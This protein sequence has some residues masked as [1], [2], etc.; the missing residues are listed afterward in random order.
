[1]LNLFFFSLLVAFILNLCFFRYSSAITTISVIK[2]LV[3]GAGTTIF[4]SRSFK[5]TL[6]VLFSVL[7][8][9][10]L[11]GNLPIIVVPTMFYRVTLS[12]R[13]RL[14]LMLMIRG[15][16]SSYYNNISHL[17]PYARPIALRVL[18]PLIETLRQC[19]RPL[20]LA[21]RLRTNL[22]AGHIMVY[23]FSYFMT[24]LPAVGI[25]RLNVAV[26]ALLL[27]EL[28]I[29]ALQAYIFVRLINLYAL[30]TEE[31]LAL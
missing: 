7:L 8:A 24:L 26:L 6:V 2:A 19:L 25:V 23:I 3:V 12:V 5:T 31:S 4:R 30:E 10:N 9:V 22:A 29:R 21:V 18:L 17:L 11:L 15:L 16:V 14:W 28:F 20:T 27:L 1:M 13:V